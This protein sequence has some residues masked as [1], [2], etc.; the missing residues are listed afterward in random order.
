MKIRNLSF[1]VKLALTAM[2][3]G[4]LSPSVDIHDSSLTKA[5]SANIIFSSLFTQAEARGTRV[6]AA[7]TQ[8]N[9]ARPLSR[10]ANIERRTDGRQN[11]NAL[12]DSRYYNRNLPYYY[13]DFYTGGGYYVGNDYHPVKKKSASSTLKNLPIGA[14]ISPAYIGSDCM[15]ININSQNY[16]KCGNTYL[17]PFFEKDILKYKVVNSPS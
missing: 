10:S 3:V 2:T 6:S 15:N 14:I 9:T 5:S 12:R 17:K 16:Q 11:K 1:S 7:R 13:S 8:V 4:F